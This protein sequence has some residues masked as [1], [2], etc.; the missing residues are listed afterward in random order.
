MFVFETV[1]SPQFRIAK[2]GHVIFSALEMWTCHLF[3]F[4][5]VYS[6]HVHVSVSFHE[7]S[8]VGQNVDSPHF[9]VAKHV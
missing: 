3:R 5:N 9:G 6:P 2:C 4:G 1:D 8:A 7:F